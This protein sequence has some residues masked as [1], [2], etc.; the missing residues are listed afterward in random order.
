MVGG[1][2]E[3]NALRNEGNK[4]IEYDFHRTLEY[5]LGGKAYKMEYWKYSK[6]HYSQ[7]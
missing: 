4:A 7:T 3:R 6:F 2:E 1:W 5:I